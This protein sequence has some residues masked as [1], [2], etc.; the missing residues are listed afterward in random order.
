MQG[1]GDRAK[2]L[3]YFLSKELGIPFSGEPIGKTERF[4]MYVLLYIFVDYLI[5]IRLDI[6]FVLVM[7]WECPH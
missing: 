6:L 2:D 7:E 4:F 5:G 3:S 1:S